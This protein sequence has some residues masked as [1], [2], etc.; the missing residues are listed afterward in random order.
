M[1]TGNARIIVSMNTS[2]VPVTIQKTLKLKQCSLG[3]RPIQL[4]LIGLQLKTV[5]MVAATQK[6]NTTMPTMS[7][8]SRKDALTENRR[9]YMR[10]MEILM[11]VITLK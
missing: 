3:T 11:A 10:R 5:A 2:K 7:D 9:R 1:R 8:C 4:Y 6:T